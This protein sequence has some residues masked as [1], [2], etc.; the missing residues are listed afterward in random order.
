MSQN[1]TFAKVSSPL[2]RYTTSNTTAIASRPSGRTISIGWIGWPR[3]FTRLSIA[4]APLRHAW[5]CVFAAFSTVRRVA[6]Q[7]G[8]S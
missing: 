4:D 1:A 2:A 7:S 8:R 5:H 6:F 3:S